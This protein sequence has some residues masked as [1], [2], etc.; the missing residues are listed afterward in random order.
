MSE[1]GAHLDLEELWP[2]ASELV[3]LQFEGEDDFHRCQAILWEHLDC[4]RGINKWDRY[5][6]IRKTDLHLIQGAGL[7]Y[8]PVELGEPTENPTE[9]E[10]A[11][12]RAML[13]RYMALWLNELGWDK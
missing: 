10:R 6:V 5:I 8:S 9:E 4:Y 2:P 13:K 12:Q 3:G 1:Q 7:K 11:D